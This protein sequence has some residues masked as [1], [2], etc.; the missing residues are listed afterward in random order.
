MLHKFYQT[1]FIALAIVEYLYQITYYGIL[2]TVFSL[3]KIL[4]LFAFNY[5]KKKV[6][7][8]L[9]HSPIITYTLSY[10]YKL[11]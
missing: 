11:H 7:A 10:N 9:A 8:I 1:N 2:L 4:S 3:Q 6:L 5:K